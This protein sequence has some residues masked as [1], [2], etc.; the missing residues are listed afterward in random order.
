VCSFCY[1]TC[2]RSNEETTTEFFCSRLLRTDWVYF[3]LFFLFSC[4]LGLIRLVLEAFLAPLLSSSAPGD[5]PIFSWGRCGG[6][7]GSRIST[8][9]PLQNRGYLPLSFRRGGSVSFTRGM[10]GDMV[11]VYIGFGQG[12]TNPPTSKFKKVLN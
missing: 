7:R 8:D 12:Y 10:F 2:S 11:R 5:G 1:Y 9:P 4:F 3:L 6:Y